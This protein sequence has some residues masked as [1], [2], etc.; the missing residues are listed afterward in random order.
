MNKIKSKDAFLKWFNQANKEGAYQNSARPMCD[1]QD[2][3]AHSDQAKLLSYFIEMSQNEKKL[4]V[5]CIAEAMGS[6][7][8]FEFIKKYSNNRA[9]K[10]IELEYKEVEKRH[11]DLFDKEIVFRNR[12]AKLELTI[13]NLEHQNKDLRKDNDTLQKTVT[14]YYNHNLELQD[15]IGDMIERVAKLEEFEDHIKSLLNK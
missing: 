6:E 15:K 7:T 1:L 10:Q 9:R 5:F 3:F 4:A 13:K 2:D 12:Q 11:M 14:R 8:L